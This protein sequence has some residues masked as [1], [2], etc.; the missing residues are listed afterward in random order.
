MV[1]NSSDNF[2]NSNRVSVKLTLLRNYDIVNIVSVSVVCICGNFE[3][4]L[5]YNV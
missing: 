5:R 1:D 3:L 2:N 4:P